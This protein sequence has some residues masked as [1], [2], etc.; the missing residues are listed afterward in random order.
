MSL[1]SKPSDFKA[2]QIVCG[3]IPYYS[4]RQAAY[5]FLD[6]TNWLQDPIVAPYLET[7]LHKN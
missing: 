7:D 3:G 4:G 5:L 1:L 2:M 6:T